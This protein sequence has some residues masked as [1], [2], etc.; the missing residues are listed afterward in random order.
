MY[1]AI[2]TN[3][4]MGFGYTDGTGFINRSLMFDNNLLY[5][6]PPLFPTGNTYAID[7]WDEIE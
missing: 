2:A 7:L 1:G 5:S 6:P 4:R 3:V